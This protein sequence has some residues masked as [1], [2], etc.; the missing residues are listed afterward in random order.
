M[1]ILYNFGPVVTNDDLGLVQKQY[2]KHLNGT[3]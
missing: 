1:T 2:I 3:K